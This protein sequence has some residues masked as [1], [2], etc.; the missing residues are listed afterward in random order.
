MKPKQYIIIGDTKG[1]SRVARIKN[2]W[3]YAHM[4]MNHGCWFKWDSPVEALT[5]AFF[6]Q[7]MLKDVMTLHV[8]AYYHQPLIAERVA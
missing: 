8:E 1:G 7:K 5:E 3:I 6:L 2:G 4:G